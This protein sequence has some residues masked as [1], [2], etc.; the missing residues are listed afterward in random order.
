MQDDTRSK[1]KTFT[2]DSVDEYFQDY[3]REFVA[4]IRLVDKRNLDRASKVMKWAREFGMRVFVAGNGGSASISEHLEC[5]WQKGTDRLTRK[6]LLTRSL[7]SN[8]ALI[9]AIGN[10]L[11]YEKIFT[12][13]LRLSNAVEGELLV[14]ISSSGNSPN[15]VE[16][17]EWAKNKRMIV[18]GMTGFDGGKLRGLCDISIHVPFRNYG[19][20]EDCHQM[21]MH[22]LAQYHD[23]SLPGIPS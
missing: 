1:N 9:T 15:I 22:V 19:I 4:A 2:I 12:E 7:S 3:L 18:I 23:L 13:Q 6:P 5:D 17:A 21:L 10:D 20:V 14:L 16:A 11:G 8:L